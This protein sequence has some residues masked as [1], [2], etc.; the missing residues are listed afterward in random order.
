MVHKQTYNWGSPCC[1][2]LTW[3][4]TTCDN[5]EL[6]FQFTNPY[7]GIAQMFCLAESFQSLKCD[8]RFPMSNITRTAE[9][10]PCAIVVFVN[11]VSFL[12]T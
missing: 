11:L 9:A 6:V 10:I 12:T 3:V 4:V 2:W 5:Q 8:F 7:N 1:E